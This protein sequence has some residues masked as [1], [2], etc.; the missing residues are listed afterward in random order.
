MDRGGFFSLL[1]SKPISDALRYDGSPSGALWLFCNPRESPSCTIS[2]LSSNENT[3]VS[4]CSE[5]NSER[6]PVLHDFLGVL[7]NASEEISSESSTITCCGNKRNEKLNRRNSTVS[8]D[9]KLRVD[10]WVIKKIIQESDIGDLSRLLLATNSVNTHIFTL[11]DAKS[12]EKVKNGGVPVAVWDSDTMSEHQ[13]LFKQW[14]SGSYV[15][16][17]EWRSAFVNRRRL[18][19][20]DEIGLY[21]DPTNSRF[22]FTILKRA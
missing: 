3:M 1:P 6:K 9:L 4:S 17:Q 16:I 14:A 18:N 8:L 10:P 12:I 2:S 5:D 13:L 15:L 11:W 19:K 7:G 20:G 21:W 22:N